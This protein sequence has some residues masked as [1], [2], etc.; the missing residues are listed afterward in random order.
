MAIKITVPNHDQMYMYTVMLT[1]CK[2]LCTKN[3]S[4]YSLKNLLIFIDVRLVPQDHRPYSGRIEVFFNNE[5]GQICNNLLGLGTLRVVCSQIG[6][7]G[8][9]IQGFPTNLPEN[10]RIWIY[11]VNCNGTE[12]TLLDCQSFDTDYHSGNVYGTCSAAAGVT[13]SSGKRFNI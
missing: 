4:M 12:N 6:Y 7:P 13:C 10:S 1:C 5:W 8:T 3:Y 9:D 11:D 2:R